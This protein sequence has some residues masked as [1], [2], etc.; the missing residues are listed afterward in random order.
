MRIATMKSALDV[1][2][3]V[4]ATCITMSAVATLCRPSA[5]MM[6]RSC[7]NALVNAMTGTSTVDLD[8]PGGL[9][10]RCPPCGVQG[11]NHGGSHRQQHGQC[12]Q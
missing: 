3:S 1:T 12:D 10:L 8:L 11:G 2:A 7:I 6:G 4:S 5:A 9:G